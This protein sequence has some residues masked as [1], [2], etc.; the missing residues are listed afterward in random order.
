MNEREQHEAAGDNPYPQ[1]YSPEHRVVEAARLDHG[2]TDEQV[3]Q[4]TK[5]VPNDGTLLRDELI[6]LYR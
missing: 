3:L 6:A 1:P 5:W 4:A 2:L